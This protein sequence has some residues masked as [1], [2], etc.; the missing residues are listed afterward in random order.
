[1]DTTQKR[2]AGTQTKQS[3]TPQAYRQKRR[4]GKKIKQGPPLN[5]NF[6]PIRS[7]YFVVVNS[8]DQRP[9]EQNRND[10]HR[11]AANPSAAGKNPHPTPSAQHEINR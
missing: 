2:R 9:S 11:T 5:P 4:V 7:N 10:L 3:P 1:K 6:P 8:V